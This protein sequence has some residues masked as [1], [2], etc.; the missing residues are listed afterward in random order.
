MP[1]ARPQQMRW[2]IWFAFF[3]LCLLLSSSWMLPAGATEES[4]IAQQACFYGLVGLVALIFAY[5]RIRLQWHAC[6]RVA[7]AS[8]LLLGVPSVLGEWARDGISDINRAALFALVPFVVVMV[9]ATRESET[10]VRRFSIPALIGFGGV[11]LLLPFSFPTSPRG[12]IVFGVLL[13]VVALVGFASEAIYRLLR[14][15]GMIEALAV[16]SISN[17]V[18]LLTCHFVNLPSAESG[19]GMSSVFSI[20]SLYN[21]V[22]LFLLIWLLREMS[23]M[24]LA[25]RY[26]I[27]PLFTVLEGFAFLHPPL[28]IRM[29]AGLVLLVAGASYL[30]SSRGGD[31]DAVLSI[32]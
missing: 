30:L 7:A 17:A 14:G 2:S 11:L 31:S 27:V 18:F 16:V 4:S 10:G 24:R 8:I 29:G 21:L 12:Q 20:H 25:V 22:E 3:T 6:L 13:V 23:P 5:R 32:R 19:S 15:F 9:A 1:R 28:T 26:L